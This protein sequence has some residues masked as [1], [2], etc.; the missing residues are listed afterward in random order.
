MAAIMVCV[1]VTLRCVL[2]QRPGVGGLG[3]AQPPEGGEGPRD[4]RRRRH[5]VGEEV[6]A[7]RHGAPLGPAPFLA[8]RPPPPGTRPTTS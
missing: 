8:P 1:C 2:P 6:D 3:E 5:P 4:G 7:H